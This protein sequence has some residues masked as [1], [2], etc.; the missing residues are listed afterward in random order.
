M[1]IRGKMLD[2]LRGNDLNHRVHVNVLNLARTG[3]YRGTSVTRLVIAFP[4]PC[5]KVN[6][7]MKPRFTD[8]SPFFPSWYVFQCLHSYLKLPFKS[9][10][11]S[12]PFCFLARIR[13]DK[14]IFRA[15]V[16]E[17]YYGLIGL[18]FIQ[19][20]YLSCVYTIYLWRRRFNENFVS[21]IVNI[22]IFV[23]RLLIY[24]R[25]IYYSIAII[26]AHFS[27]LDRID[28]QKRM[29]SRHGCIIIVKLFVIYHEVRLVINQND[30]NIFTLRFISVSGINFSAERNILW[31][32]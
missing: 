21:R 32:R 29:Q 23:H 7:R 15:N 1:Q 25:T 30:D 20:F 26:N 31:Q 16:F 6:S 24:I 27:Q 11:V 3:I 8:L 10:S 4:P 12:N 13:G 18:L 22:Y 28:F 19:R 9:K 5:G 14:K 2:N 17:H